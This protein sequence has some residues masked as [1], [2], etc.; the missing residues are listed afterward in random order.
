M[1]IEKLPKKALRYIIKKLKQEYDGTSYGDPSDVYEYSDIQDVIDSLVKPFGAS[2]DYHY[3][4]GFFWLLYVYNKN[5]DENEDLLIPVKKKLTFNANV[6]VRK[7]TT[8][9]YAHRTFTYSDDKGFNESMIHSDDDWNYYDGDYIDDDTYDS[10]A[11]EW[12]IR[13]IETSP[14]KES[15]GNRKVITE[16]KKRKLEILLK[17]KEYI[18]NEIRKITT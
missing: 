2:I 9:I 7:Y 5:K 16:D 17:Q 10:D 12:E 3:E 18:E 8:E 6:D 11:G 1:K 14:L 4:Y 13:H 15:I